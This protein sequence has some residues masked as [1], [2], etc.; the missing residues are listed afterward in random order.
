MISILFTFFEFVFKALMT[1]PIPLYLHP[2]I[3]LSD[4]F[5]FITFQSTLSY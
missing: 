5:T 4:P 1:L 3:G 2:D